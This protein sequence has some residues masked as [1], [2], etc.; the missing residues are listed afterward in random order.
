MIATFSRFSYVFRWPLALVMLVCTGLVVMLGGGRFS[1]FSSQ[2]ASFSDDPATFQ[3]QP[4]DPRPEVFI[5]SDEPGLLALYDIE[6]EYVPEDIILIAFEESEHPHG[7]FSPESLQ[8]VARLTE[9]LG[10]VPYVRHV[11]SLTQSPWIRWG[12]IENDEDGLLVTDLFEN[13]PQTYSDD[14][15]LTRMIAVLGARRS[16][17]LVGEEEVRRVLGPDARFEDHIGE[18]RLLDGIISN[19]GRTTA[20]QVQVLRP[21]VGIEALDG[22]F[23]DDLYAKAVAPA[24]YAAGAQWEAFVDIQEIVAEETGHEFHVTGLPRWQHNFQ[25]AATKDMRFTGLMFVVVGVV[26]FVAFRRVSAVLLPYIIIA[27][28]VGGMMGA[29]LLTGELFNNITAMMPSVL[30]AIGVADSVHLLAAYFVLRP[31]YDDKRAL[32]IEV[33]RRNA[34]PVFLTTVTTAIGFA[35]LMSSSVVPVRHF[36][37]A[38]AVGAVVTYML[39]MTLIPALLSLIPVRRSGKEAAPK[40]Q[41]PSGRIAR[42][43]V[44]FTIRKRRSIVISTLALVAVSVVGIARLEVNAD[45]TSWFGDDNPTVEDLLWLEGHLGGTR[46]LEVVFEGPPPP[47]DELGESARAARIEELTIATLDTSAPLS[48]SDRA[49]LARLEEEQQRV[50][51]G[52]IAISSEFIDALDR[53]ERRLVAESRDRESPLSIFTDVESP[54]DVLRKMHQAQNESLGSYYRVP[55]ANDVPEG[56]RAPS[57]MRD[58]VLGTEDLI[59]GQTASSLLS[60]YYLQYENGAKPTESLSRLV[61]P[62]QRGFRLVARMTQA[63]TATQLAAFDRIDAIAQEEFPQIAGS[64]EE[65]AAGQALSTMTV[66]G[67]EYLNSH[68]LVRFSTSLATS[69]A[70]ALV[71]ISLLIAVVFRSVKLGLV[72]MIPNVVPLVVPLAFFGFW[73]LPLDAPAVVVAAIALGICVD[74]TIHF[75]IRFSEAQRQG[76]DTQASIQ[77]V[78]DEAGIP[79]TLTTIALMAGFAV[80]AL[81]DFRPNFLVGQLAL[82]MIGLAWVADFIVTPAVLSYFGRSDSP[83]KD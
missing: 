22:A 45:F 65:V 60:Q 4:M 33:I 70:I 35:S 16:V 68:M 23:G 75:L 20:L 40:E 19:D 46:G 24:L 2:V 18:P 48:Q 76:C 51:R 53:F 63:P 73:D 26:M 52:R 81:S 72:S 15:R 56:A 14:E 82:V 10:R 38:G 7:A 17:E 6:R 43:L 80:V 49:E 55:S 77:Y 25:E 79:L 36:G 12:A 78:F 83:S 3:A 30:T 66:T 47:T 64:V 31:E 13:A 32:L 8:T 11:R 21:R 41:R 44:R 42:A 62:D 39:S 28:S 57:V 67:R 58:P 59:P 5:D 74:D 69:M 37:L 34:V 61:R 1:E 9:K 54:L 71:A 29:I 27:A 50:D